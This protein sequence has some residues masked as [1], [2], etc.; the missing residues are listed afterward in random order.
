MIGIGVGHR[1]RAAHRHPLPR[2][3]RARARPR[4]AWSLASTPPAAPCS[5]PALTVVIS[6]LGMFLIGPRL[7]HGLAIGR[8]SACSMTMLRRSRCCP[9]CSASSGRNIDKFGLPHRKQRRGRR[10]ESRSGTAGAGSSSG[11][12]G[13]RRSSAGRPAHRARAAGVL[14]AAGLRRR[15]QPAHVRHDAGGPTTC[16]PR[17]SGPA[18]TARCI[19]AAEMPDGPARPGDRSRAVRSSCSST[20][21]VAFGHA[22]AARTRRRRRDHARCSRPPRRRTRRPPTWWTA[23]ATT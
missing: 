7:V 3:A 1:L 16:S 12:R 22:A 13:L 23:C 10:S 8:R 9:P 6:L 19:L 21:G 11:T 14:A 5:S 2:G 18:S 17:A 15:R 20:P 4:G